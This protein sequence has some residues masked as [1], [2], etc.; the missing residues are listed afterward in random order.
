MKK[1]GRRLKSEQNRINEY[2]GV[3]KSFK[4]MKED[5]EDERG[6]GQ[7]G[8]CQSHKTFAKHPV[9]SVQSLEREVNAVGQSV[10]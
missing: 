5:S 10:G 8:S 3:Q 6:R 7:W 4:K 9:M 2:K 1:V